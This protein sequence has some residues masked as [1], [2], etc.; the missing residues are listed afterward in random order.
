MGGMEQEPLL[1]VLISQASTTFGTLDYNLLES[2]ESTS[3]PNEFNS[4]QTRNDHCRFIGVSASSN[5]LNTI[6]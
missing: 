4:W 3:H 5:S 2:R 6:L 1:R